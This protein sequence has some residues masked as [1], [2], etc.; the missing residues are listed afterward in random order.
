MSC[1]PT[2]RRGLSLNCRLFVKGIQKA[3]RLLGEASKFATS[4]GELMIGDPVSLGGVTGDYQ[5]L[6]AATN[7]RAGR[8]VQPFLLGTASGQSEEQ[9]Y[10]WAGPPGGEGG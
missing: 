3:S 1:A 10:A 9:P 2:S 7:W 4:T 8:L 5:R 6:T